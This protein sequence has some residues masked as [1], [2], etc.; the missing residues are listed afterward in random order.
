MRSKQVQRFIK[1]KKNFLGLSALLC[2]LFEIAEL[3][4]LLIFII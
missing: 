1:A 4:E 2:I 3:N